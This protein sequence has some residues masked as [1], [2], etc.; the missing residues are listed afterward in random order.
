MPT[1]TPEPIFAIQ[2]DAVDRRRRFNLLRSV[3][4]TERASYEPQWRD[5]QDYLLPTRTQFTITD[6]NRGDRRNQKIIDETGSMALRALSNNMMARLTSPARPWKKLTVQDSALAEFGPVK[7][8]LSVVNSRMDSVFARSNLY[9][10]FPG[11]YEDV[12][13]FATGAMFVEEDFDTTIHTTVFPLGSYYLGL[14][15]RLQVDIFYREFRLTVRQLIQR[16]GER[17]EDGTP[18]WDKFSTQVQNLYERGSY[19]AWVDVCHIIQPNERYNPRDLTSKPYE[20]VYFEKGT[21][22]GGA[23]ALST[24][25][26]SK[27]LRDRGYDFFPVLAGRWFVKG[28]D[29]YGT[30]CPG[31]MAIGGIKQLQLGEKRTMQAVEKMINPAM[32]APTSLRQ[33]RMSILPGDVTFV[34][35]REGEKGFRAAHDVNFQI[36]PMEVKQAQLR[37]RINKIFFNN[38]FLMFTE[39]DRRQITATEVAARQEEKLILGAVLEQLNQDVYD[40]LIDITFDI[41]QRRG[42]IPEPPEELQGQDLKVEYIST[43][44]QAMKSAGLAGIDNLVAFTGEAM[45]LDPTIIDKIDLDQVIDVRAEILGVPPETVRSDDEVAE[46]RAQRAQA[47]QAEQAQLALQEGA[48]TAKTLSETDTGGE[49]ALTEMIAQSDAGAVV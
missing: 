43:L 36:A 10:S 9:N 14:N 7:E 33:A 25:D 31:M 12:T 30:N 28:E 44:H 34:D 23:A 6:T 8:W 42:M 27:Y 2:G 21:Q 18:K 26:K 13:G 47:A 22:E 32:V 4:E 15:D 19:E 24:E 1:S 35:L 5:L 11:F 38:L 48:N 3:L 29:T 46:I 20:S 41:M 16:F 40:P 39:T 45:A 37:E 49:N 17:K